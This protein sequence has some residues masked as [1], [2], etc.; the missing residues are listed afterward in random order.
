MAEPLS[1]TNVK[2]PGL[3]PVKVVLV[4]LPDGRVVPRAPEELK[5]K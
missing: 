4:K 2:V 5:K 1:S 3:E